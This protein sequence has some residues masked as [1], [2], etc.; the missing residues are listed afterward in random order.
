M[1]CI[2]P[3]R[4]RILC[5]VEAA[6]PTRVGPVRV[7]ETERLRH[8]VPDAPLDEQVRRAVDILT[9]RLRPSDNPII[10]GNH[11]R[12]TADTGWQPEIPIERTLS[13]LLEYWRGR[14]ALMS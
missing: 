5:T 4:R 8:V 6:S 14:E 7:L 9:E 11:D 13:D 12:L 3:C 1:P 10:A 2:R